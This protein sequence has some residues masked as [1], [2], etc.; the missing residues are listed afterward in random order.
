MKIAP[1][2]NDGSQKKS[3]PIFPLTDE[4]DSYVLDKSNSV[5]WDLSTQPGTADAVTYK[6]VARV[7]DG[8]E[9]PR[10]IIRWRASVTKV[11][12]GLNVTTLETKL[13]II[14]AMMR[15]QPLGI[16]RQ[17][18]T[19]CARMAY[20]TALR[21][22]ADNAARQVIIGQGVDHY[23]VVAHLDTAV[24]M[25]VTNLLPMKALAKSKRS[26]RRN[27]R[28]PADMTVRQYYQC[29]NR[30]NT[31]ELP[32]L[33]P[34]GNN[35]SFSEEEMIEILLFGTPKS[36]QVEMDRLGFDPM[37]KHLRTVVEFMENLEA[38]EATS[39]KPVE[40][41]K[42]ASSDKSKSGKSDK[43]PASKK[44]APF[45]CKLHGPNYSHD[46]KDCN[47][48]KRQ[49]E[50][51]SKNKVWKRKSEESKT[52]TKKE[53]AALVSKAVAKGVK[54]ELAAISKGK[55]KS[56]DKEDSDDDG[57]CYLLDSIV[58]GGLDGFNYEEMENLKID[59][60]DEI[61]V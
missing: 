24:N 12:T 19:A 49:G 32:N 34:F 51:G 22:A 59:S 16:F 44:K 61:S 2:K 39:F 25:T 10:Q 6:Y 55:R 23:R 7:L 18:L 8:S 43:E 1:S 56:D 42:K 38:A 50:E 27:M 20:D 46:T 37:E 52:A 29:L 36:W 11:T 5:S 13:P 60:D 57:E 45:Y 58:N 26:V 40:G 35:Q 47:G 33:P 30:I 21:G 14:E 17:S 48:L 3:S 9:T 54:K 15:P 28:K 41:K 53:L 31:E 4:E